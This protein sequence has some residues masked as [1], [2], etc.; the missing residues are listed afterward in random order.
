MRKE[1]KYLA[2]ITVVIVAFLLFSGCTTNQDNNGEE[3]NQDENEIPCEGG[4][5]TFDYPPADLDKV[6]IYSSSRMYV[7]WACYSC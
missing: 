2:I 3:T 1:N 4:Y 7:W 6:L 5:I